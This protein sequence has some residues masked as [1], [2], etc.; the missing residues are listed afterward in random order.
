MKVRFAPSPTGFLHIGNARTAIINYILAKKHD[1]GYVLRVEDTD[2]ER[3]TLESEKS[4]MADLKWLGIEWTEGPDIGGESGPYRQSERFDIYREYT[5]KLLAEGKA[6]YCYCTKE[7]LEASRK[8]EEGNVVSYTYNGHCR[9]LTDDQRAAYEKEGRKPTVRFRV[10][11]NETVTVKDF[12]KGERDFNTDHIGGDFIIVRS[13]GIPI[14]N[15]IV[16]IDDTL[17]GVTHVIRGEDHFSN[18]PKQILI[19]RALGMPEPSYAHQP[20]IMGEDRKKLSKRHGI[21]S[22]DLYRKEGY[23]PEALVNYLSLLGWAT[24]SGDEILSLDELVSQFS[25]EK[26][27]NSAAIFDFKKLRWMNGQ[28]INNYDL[29]RLTDLMIP[30]ISDAGFDPSSFEREALEKIIDLVRGSC[31]VL[32]DIKN[33]IGIFLSAV[34]EP[35]EAADNRLKSE[36]APEIIN[37]AAEILET[38]LTESDFAEKFVDL[39]NEK[40]EAKGKPFFMTVRAMV[41]MKQKGPDIK[42]ALPLIG[43]D[44]LKKRVA[45]CRER[46]C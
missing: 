33:F 26:L 16:S 4:I 20:L 45:L 29:T 42:L 31:E 32:E 9:D 10:P 13:D 36:A 8:D 46:Y 12:L 41:T 15:Y 21:T 34:P 11:D 27:G 3:S 5:E 2:R 25:L 1:A 14:Y 6:Y 38:D 43:F 35:D 24:E 40:T 30:Y 39:L 23:L 18:T 19:A 7:E 22:V 37:A 17:M 28:Y 44:N